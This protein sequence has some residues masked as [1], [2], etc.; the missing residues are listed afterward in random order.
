MSHT[1]LLGRIAFG[2]CLDVARWGAVAQVP[3]TLAW[4]PERG[5]KLLHPRFDVR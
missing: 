3:L 2:P 1:P 4:A 5:A